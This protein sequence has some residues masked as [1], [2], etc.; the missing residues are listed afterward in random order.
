MYSPTLDEFLKP[1]ARGNL[2]SVT[3]RRHPIHRLTRFRSKIDWRKS[4]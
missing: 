3:R 4:V 2:F 1:A